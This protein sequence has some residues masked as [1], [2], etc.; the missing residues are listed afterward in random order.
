MLKLILKSVGAYLGGT[1]I[2]IVATVAHAEF[3]PLAVIG[4]LLV[5]TC[6]LVS[7][8]L[9]ADQRII[10]VAGAVGVS[11]SVFLLAQ[12]SV[13]GSVLIAAGDAGNYWFLGSFAIA[14]LVSVWP[15]LRQR[16]RVN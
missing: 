1:I 5:V 8:R 4:S 7:L 9:L 13:G 2:A 6:Y 12:K 3:Y 10:Q 15:D 14:A 11:L 16:S